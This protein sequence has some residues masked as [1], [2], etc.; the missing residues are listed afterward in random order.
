MKPLVLLILDG[1]GLSPIEEGNAILGTPTPNFD[2][3]VG[4]FPSSLLHASGEEVGLSWGEMG[5]SEVGH[6]N[7]GTG[8]VAIQDLPRINKSIID[9]T[10]FTNPSLLA[11]FRFAEANNSN[12]HLIGL[13]SGGGVHGHIDHLLALL[14]MAKKQNFERVFIHIITDGRDTPAKAILD[15]LKI[16]EQKMRKCR[17]GK[18]ATVMGRF[19]AMDRDKRTDRT[20]KAFTVLT[21]EGGV[22]FGTAEEIIENNYAAG[23]TD[24]FI[25]PASISATAKVKP[26]D[27]VIF[28][29]FRT[30]RS[31]QLADLIVKIN[32][33]F[34]VSFTNYGNEQSHFTRI[35]FFSENIVDQL[36]TV[37]SVNNLSQF[38]IAETEKFPHVTYFFNGGEEKLNSGEERCIIPSPKVQTYDQAPEM[39]AGLLTKKFNDFFLKSRPNFTV[40]NFAN[41]DMVGH[42]G[43]YLATQTAISYVDRCLGEVAATVLNNGA[44]LM[45]TADHG[46][47]EQMVNLQTGEVNKEHTTNPVPLVLAFAE[48][49]KERAAMGQDARIAFAAQTPIGVLADVTATIIHRLNINQS[50]YITGQSLEQFL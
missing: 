36:S 15:D 20:K 31:R 42:T 46:N 8:R 14:D 39:S 50:Q 26:N 38:H 49:K 7:L 44:D 17:V 40:L 1:W 41:A 24:E 3:L 34:F 35:A 29:N 22:S 18:I 13:V 10:F 37:L 28:F 9:G 2:R 30:D 21:S 47:A 12:L 45:V 5:N 11:A 16:L 19:Y 48:K 25:E 6:F 4:S 33:L 23:R 27:A 32:H 43:N